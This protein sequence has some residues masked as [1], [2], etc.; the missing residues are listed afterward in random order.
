MDPA[1]PPL[2]SAAGAVSAPA[3]PAP[4]N[5][6]AGARK[7]SEDFEAV[8]LSQV[9]ENMFSSVETDQLFGGG[10][11]ESVYRS[12]L[13]QEYSKVA[14]RAGSIGIA[15]AVQREIISLQEKR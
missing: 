13:L 8:F 6:A 9:F 5:D 2:P 11:G 10:N 14:A 15:D 1:L 4:T 7:A 12:L 3:T